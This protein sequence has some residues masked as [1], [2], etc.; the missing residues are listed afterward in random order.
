MR[1]IALLVFGLSICTSQL[2][3]G[4]ADGIRHR[5]DLKITK[6][7]E[8]PLNSDHLRG[9]IKTT[10]RLVANSRETRFNGMLSSSFVSLNASPSQA[11]LIEQTKV[12]E[13]AICHQNRGYPKTTLVRLEGTFQ[14]G[15]T[16]L[17]AAKRL[18][19][20]PIPDDELSV[21]AGMS[22]G[23]DELGPHVTFRSTTRRSK[24]IV[25]M[26]IY[27]IKCELGR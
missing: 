2:P 21:E 6:G 11:V 27:P 5:I 17:F 10:I 13:E 22:T 12:W 4:A 16:K 25:D 20:K 3:A 19:G 1:T 7:P 15:E 9:E 18:T 24:L 23:K 26:R 8:S 14:P